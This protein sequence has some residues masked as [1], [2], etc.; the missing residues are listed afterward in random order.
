[1]TESKTEN[2]RNSEEQ[3]EALRAWFKPVLDNVVKEMLARKAVVGTAVEASPAWAFP[4]K[5]LIAKV[6]GMGEKS[7]FIW[8]ISGDEVITD[9]IAGN[10]AATPKD[11]ARHFALKWQ[12]DADRLLSLGNKNVPMADTK[13]HMGSYAQKLIKDAEALYELTERDLGWS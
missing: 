12:M 4:N 5:I 7:R 8:T 2:E 13:E 6:W 11:A 10:M 3:K 9:Y 1:M